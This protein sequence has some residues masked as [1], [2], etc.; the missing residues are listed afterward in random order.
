MIHKLNRPIIV[1]TIA[2]VLSILGIV[3][4]FKTNNNRGF[5]VAANIPITGYFATYGDAI[6]KGVLMYQAEHPEIAD[7]IKWDWQDNI[8]DA[9]RAVSIMQSQL[10]NNPDIYL[11]GVKPQTMAINSAINGIGLPHFVWIFDPFINKSAVKNNIRM[12]VSYKLEPPVFVKY[13]KGLNPK[14]VF[15]VYVQLPHTVE[16]FE[17]LVKPRLNHEL[18]DFA[19]IRTEVYDYGK[20]D[21]KDIVLKCK[22]FSPDLIIVSG[23]QAEL[24]NMVR[25]FLNHGLMTERNFIATYDMLDAAELLSVQELEKVHFVAPE[26]VLSTGNVVVEEWK[27]RFRKRFGKA[28]LYTHAYAYDMAQMLYDIAIKC[29]PVDSAE[30]LKEIKAYKGQGITGSLRF[31]SDMDLLTPIDVGRFDKGVPT[32]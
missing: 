11:S 8:G 24:A 4:Y 23:F 1:F 16:E 9:Q 10:I 29:K 27:E 28:P 18:G 13:A 25:E 32:K 26:F 7:T 19:E 5:L 15:I 6:K 31:D 2:T 20:R 30:W 14:K 3:L 12:W 21:F 22:G 17:Q